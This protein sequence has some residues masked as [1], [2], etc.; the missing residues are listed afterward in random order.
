MIYLPIDNE[1]GQVESEPVKMHEIVSNDLTILLVEDDEPLRKLTIVILEGIGYNVIESQSVEDAILKAEARKTPIHLVLT[2]VV[3][4]RM[5]G[6]EVFAKI[7]EHHP[8]AKVLYM[9]GYTDDIITRQGILPKGI[10]FI[11]KPFAVADLLE[12][13]EQ[14]LN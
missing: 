8:E 1:P 12:K 10:Q 9:S 14:I 3:M 6:P 7:A 11:Q 2:D 13:I 4:P 5:K